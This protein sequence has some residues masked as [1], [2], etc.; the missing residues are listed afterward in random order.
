MTGQFLSVFLIAA[1]FLAGCGQRAVD[2]GIGKETEPQTQ[3]TERMTETETQKPTEKETETETE[4]FKRVLDVDYTS[5]DGTIKITLPDNTWK[6]GQDVDEMRVFQSG[7]DAMINIVHANTE[8]ALNSL[9]VMTSQPEL[10]ASLTAQYADPN[11][12]EVLSFVDAPVGAVHVYR[13][14]VKY[15]SAA[16]MWAYSVTNAIVAPDQAYV[17]VGSIT[18]DNRS[19]LEA[20]QKSVSSFRVLKDET[21]KAVTGEVITGT[22]QA[23]PQPVK[24]DTV[25]GDELQSLKNYGTT[26]TLVTLDQ[27]NVRL[28]PGTDSDVLITLDPSVAVTVTGETANWY[29]VNVQGNTGYIRKDFLVYGTPAQTEKTSESDQETA[30]SNEPY[31]AIASAELGNETNY[32]SATTLY[33]TTDVNI[34]ALP[35]TDSD[36]SG[37][38]GT[39][40]AISVIG[41]TDNWFKVSVNGATGYIS[42]AY[43][44]ST[45]AAPTPET[46]AEQTPA[47]QTGE[48]ANTNTAQTDAQAQTPETQAPAQTDAPAQTQQGAT[49]TQSGTIVSVGPD[50]ITYQT[51]DGQTYT[52]N[53]SDADISAANGVYEGAVGSFE[54]DPS[55]TDANG[56]P[57]ATNVTG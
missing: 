34:R 52:V 53:T 23:T 41:E 50:T 13:Y 15:T 55:K 32:G 2:P 33:A 43:L 9:N 3:Q 40:G 7:K 29:Q 54:Y 11:A 45:Q 57:Y 5:K 12:F 56:N 44:S 21:L 47:A 35:G 20:V 1:F 26:T 4:A 6:I 17:V 36:I 37:S 10:E 38:L 14:T 30:E 48:N 39:G 42:K 8:S 46:T 19:L 27:I 24:T 22:L 25:S 49:Q 28:A 51:N 18:E 31:S 16:R